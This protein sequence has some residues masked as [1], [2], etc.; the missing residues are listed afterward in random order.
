MLL[1]YKLKT[2]LECQY[3][4]YLKS[5]KIKILQLLVA[6][7]RMLHQ[8]YYKKNFI[9]YTKKINELVKKNKFPGE[10]FYKKLIANAILF[11]AVDKLFGRKNIDAI[12]DTNLKSFTVAYTLSYFHYLTENRIDLWKIYEE[13]RVDSRIMNELQKLIVSFD[14]DFINKYKGIFS[15]P[16]MPVR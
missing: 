5:F 6:L 9:H 10:N 3:L 14:F 2:I 15:F 7:L 1:V 4:D 13:Q 11:K 8:N 16:L 12:G